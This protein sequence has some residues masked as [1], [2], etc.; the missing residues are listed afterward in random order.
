[1]NGG[2][3]RTL[4]PIALAGGVIVG[5]GS[6]GLPVP[7]RV[8]T[9]LLA[10][11]LPPLLALQGAIRPDEVRELRRLD[12]YFSSVVLIV[13]IGGLAW[14]GGSAS[15]FEAADM[16]LV[17]VDAVA[18]VLWTVGVVLVAIG[19]LAIGR[20]LRWRETPL[21]ELLLPRSGVERAAF[22]LL[23]IA[24]GVFEELAFRGFLI[25]A[26][27]MVTDSTVLAVVLS[28]VAFGMMHGYQSIGGAARAATLGAVLAVPFLATGSLI[29][30]MA[31]HALYDVVVGLFLAD[32]VLRRPDRRH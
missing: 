14:W 4:L 5:F 21:L 2:A 13:G 16:G 30:S 17:G 29:P 9:I 7:A 3:A 1:M 23:S 19:V 10:G 22:V 8:A 12:V 31:A 11:V 32:W 20:A 18:G 27:R 28:S 6:A 26:L 15:G 25:P 24:A